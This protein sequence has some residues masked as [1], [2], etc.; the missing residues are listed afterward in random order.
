ML[1]HCQLGDAAC[2]ACLRSTW[3]RA[4]VPVRSWFYCLGRT[5][6][7]GTTAAEAAVVLRK[8]RLRFYDVT[9]IFE[10]NL[11]EAGEF[12]WVGWFRDINLIYFEIFEDYLVLIIGDGEK[13][14]WLV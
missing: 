13:F 3:L 2:C 14:G 12:F 11:N 4:K 10:S 7:R 1:A 6:L 8:S 9:L 5:Q